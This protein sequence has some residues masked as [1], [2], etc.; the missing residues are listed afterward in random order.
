LAI[1]ALLAAGPLAQA[2]TLAAPGTVTTTLYSESEFVQ[3]SKA[4][5]IPI[6]LTEAGTLTIDVTDMTFP[7]DFASLSFQIASASST[8]AK[9]SAPGVLTLTISGPMTLYADV[10]A[11]AQGPS[12][13]GLFNLHAQFSGAGS[14]PLPGSGVLLGWLLGLLGFVDWRFRQRT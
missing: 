3:G 12:D 9:M 8:M 1:A 6:Q 14:V 4:M 13:V 10:F 11:T 5:V 7:I 2:A